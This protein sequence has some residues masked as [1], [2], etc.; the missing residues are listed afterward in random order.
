MAPLWCSISHPLSRLA[1]QW[2]I[3][4][5]RKCRLWACCVVLFQS[6]S[7]L[8][9][10][11]SQPQSYCESRGE[12]DPGKCGAKREKRRPDDAA[13]HDPDE[14]V[15]PL[16]TN[17]TLPLNCLTRPCQ[18]GKQNNSLAWS[19]LWKHCF[20][21]AFSAEIKWCQ[22]FRTQLSVCRCA[23]NAVS[24]QWLVWSASSLHKSE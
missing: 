7:S 5:G 10:H 6:S 9:R 23:S 17:A 22:L 3:I 24:A 13:K 4:K 19:S 11:D 16:R 2:V 15:F 8:W 21:S 20:C 12:E 18:N 14:R 1:V